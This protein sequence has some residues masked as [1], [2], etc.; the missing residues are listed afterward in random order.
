MRNLFKKRTGELQLNTILASSIAQTIY[1]KLQF[2]TTFISFKTIVLKFKKISL[3][4]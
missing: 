1:Y 4:K 2:E 3:D